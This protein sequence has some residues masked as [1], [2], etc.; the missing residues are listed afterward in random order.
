M[1]GLSPARLTVMNHYVT[2]A[3]KH[4]GEVYFY[5]T[6]TEDLNLSQYRGGDLYDSRCVDTEQ[7][8]VSDAK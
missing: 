5:L 8:C 7:G 4:P 6:Y 3:S 2:G 1:H